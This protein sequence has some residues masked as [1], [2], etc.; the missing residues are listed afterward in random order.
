MAKPDVKYTEHSQ[1]MGQKLYSK[2]LGPTIN[3]KPNWAY[4]MPETINPEN[5]KTITPSEMKAHQERQAIRGRLRREF[6]TKKY[7]PVNW[8]FFNPITSDPMYAK[9]QNARSVYFVRDAFQPKSLAGIKTLFK[10]GFGVVLL[11][12][13]IFTYLYRGT[14]NQ[15]KFASALDPR[16][17]Q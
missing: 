3:F 9:F 4:D 6:W 16:V 1:F 12:I 14:M 13:G 7:H 17:N 15:T 8:R 5:W 10:I 2:F 11:P